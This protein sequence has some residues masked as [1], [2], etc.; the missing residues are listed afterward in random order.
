MLTINV[1][2]GN[3]IDSIWIFAGRNSTGSSASQFGHGG[4]S[5]D[6]T[7]WSEISA[8][9][10]K[11][12]DKGSKIKVKP[13]GN[14]QYYVFGR[15]NI[16]ETDPSPNA[17]TRIYKLIVAYS[18]VGAASEWQV[19]GLDDV[20]WAGFN[21]TGTETVSV[22]RLLEAKHEYKFKLYN[23]STS[24]WWGNGTTYQMTQGQTIE[25]ADAGANCK[26]RT[27][28]AGT[29]TFSFNTSTKVL[30]VIY[31]DDYKGYWTKNGASWSKVYA[32]CYMDG[33]DSWR[34]AEWPGVEITSQTE[35]IC[36]T[37][38][39]INTSGYTTVIFN[40]GSSG[41]GNQTGNIAISGGEG[42]HAVGAAATGWTAYPTYTV[43]YD[44]NENTGGSVPTDS[45]SP[46][47]CGS[48]VTVLGNT[49]S[50]VR[51]GYNFTGWN[52]EANGSGTGYTA[53]KTF[54]ISANTTLY[55]QW[56]LIPTYDITY[57][58]NEGTGTT[59]SQTG[60]L[61]GAVVA[62]RANGFT[63]S[64]YKFKWW[65]T[66]ADGSGEDFYPGEKVTIASS[67]VT[68]YAQWEQV[69]SG[70][71][72][73]VGDDAS[74]PTDIAGN[75]VTM[76]LA[77][78]ADYNTDFS[79]ASTVVSKYN[80][81]VDKRAKV[82]GIGADDKYVEISFTDG[83]P[84]NS[85]KLGVAGKDGA[86]DMIVIYSTTADFSSGV[87]EKV[88]AA[89][90]A[91]T[92]S[93]KQVKDFS[94]SVANKYFYARVY[95]NVTTAIYGLTGGS[96][97][98]IRVYSIK[99]QK[100]VSCVAPATVNV[101]ATVNSV[102]GFQ[103]YPDDD[104]VLT[105]TPTG[106]P[107]G[108]PVTYQ[109]KKNGSNVGTNS[110]TLTIN[111]AAASDAG[112]YTCTISYGA[113]STTSAEFSLKCM[114]FLLKN[115]SGEDIGTP[116]ALIKEDATHATL[117][118]NLTGGTTYKFRV[119][120][121]CNNWYGNSD[122]TGITSS[123]CTNWTMPH[124][125]D[126]KVTTNSKTGTYTFNFDFTGGV[127]GSEMKVSIVYPGGNQAAG[128]IIYWDNSVL[129]W[130]AGKQWYR[131]GK[132]GHNNKTQMELVPGTANLYTITTT[133]YNGFEYWHIA[134]N[135]GEGT[136][137]IFWTKGEAA[138]AITHAMAFEEAP[139]TADAV[140]VTPSSS[141]ARGTSADNDNCDFYEYGQQEGMKTQN[142]SI[143]APSNGTI[144]VAYTDVEGASQSFTSGSADLAHTVIITPTATPNTGYTLSGLTVNEAAHTSGNTY[145]VTANTTIAATFT[146]KTYNITLDRN[147]ASSGSESVTMTYNS[148]SYTAITAPV[149]AGYT[150]DGWYDSET[151]NN[152][153]GNLVMN[154]SGVLQANVTGFTGAG[155]I[156]IKDATCTLYA[157]WTVKTTTITIDANTSNH[158]STAPSP[159]TATYSRA[160]PSF[161][162]AAG[163]GGWNLT[164]YFTAA[165][166]GTKV[167]N[168][169][170]TLVA[171][172]D[173]ADGDG[174]WKY[175][176]AT[177]T[178]YAQYE[179]D[180]E[181]CYQFEVATSGSAPSVGDAVLGTGDAGMTV[182]AKGDGSAM[183]YNSYGIKFDKSGDKLRV[184]LAD[185]IQIG[186]VIEIKQY[187]TGEG[188]NRGLDIKTTS[189]E[190]VTG[191]AMAWNPA[192]SAEEKI[193][194]LT[195][196][197]GNELIDAN[198]FLLVRKTNTYLKSVTVSNCGDAACS[199]P[200]IDAGST[201]LSF[202]GGTWAQ[203]SGHS[204]TITATGADSYEWYRNTAANDAGATKLSET[205]NTLD[206]T[207]VT[208]GIYFFKAVAKSGACSSST[209][210][211]WCGA[212]TI[213]ASGYTVTYNGNGATSGSVPVDASSP[214]ASGSNVTV[215]GNTG[216]LALA[217]YTFDGWATANDGTGTNYTADGT[218]SGIAADVELFAKWKQSITL[219]ANTSN[220]GTG[221]N[222]EATV[223]Y[224]AT[225]LSSISHATPAS[226]YKLLGYYTTA[227]GDGVKV[228]N[229]DGTFAGSN[230]T[231][232]IT[233]G[234]WS[235][236]GAAP[237][238]Y[239]R[240]ESSGALIWNLG[241]NTEATSLTTSSKHSDFTQIAGSNMAVAAV[242]GLT[243]T[244]N[245]KANLTGIIEAPTSYDGA[246]YVSVTFQVA[247][248]YKFTPSSVNVKV[249][250]K[251]N[252]KT[253]KIELSDASSH[254]QNYTSGSQSAG[255]IQ[256]VT[257]TGNGTFYTG[258][259]TLKIYCYGASGGY[260]LGTPITIEG[261]VE[262]TCVMPSFDGLNYEETSYNLD[263]NASAITVTNPANV[264][265][266][267][268]K[269]NTTNDRSGTTP[270]S[271]TN[272]KASYTPPTSEAGTMYYWCE[273]ISDCGTV[274]TPA[275]GI[276]V[277]VSKS[278]ATISWTGTSASANYGGG[279]YTVKATVNETGWDGNAADLTLSAP[280]GIHI[281][282]IES[283][284]ADGKKYVQASFDVTTAFDRGTY[285][286]TIPFVVSA[287][288][289][290]TYNA[291]SDEHAV[292]YEACTGAGEGESYKIRMRKVVTKDGNYYHCANT[293]GWI[294]ANISSSYS[295]TKASTTMAKEFDTVA[296][297]N[298]QYVWVRTYHANINKVRIYAD[299][300]AGNMTV[301]N[302]YK[303]TNYFSAD[304]KYA[305][306]YK[307]IYNG[308]E[309]YDDLGET[310]QGYVDIE[311]G[312][313]L[314]ANDVLLVA[315]NTK[316]VRPLGAVITEGSAGSLNTHLQWSG[317]LEDGATVNK[318]TTDAYFTYSASM[319]T[320]NTN[321]LG[322][323]TY[324]SS[325]PSVATVDATGKVAMVAAGTTT[326]KATLA[327]SGCYKKAEISYTLNVTEDACAIAAGT[328]TLTSGSESKCSGE[329][330]TLT[331]TDFESDATLQWKDGDT[332]I[333]NDG[334]Y[335]IV[336]DGTTS[337]LTTKQPGT[338]SVIVKKNCFV[339][340][341]RITITYK[342]TSV[343]VT[344]LVKEWY[345]KNGRL[346]PDI[347]LW[348]LGDDCSF[349]SVA[350]SDGWD[351]NTGLTAESS[352]YEQDGVVYLKGTEP[353]ANAETVQ[354]YTLTLTVN[355]GCG[356]QTLNAEGMKITIHHQQNTDKHV[357]AFVVNGT[358]KGGFTDGITAAQTTSVGLYNSIA[359]QFDV[360]ET[361]IYATDDEKKLKEYYSQYDILCL[362]D[363]PNTKT[364]GANSKSY[365]DA[366]GALI[367]IRPVLTM[368]AWV[369]GLSNWNKKGISGNPKNPTTRQYTME[370]QCKDHEIFAGTTLTE[371]GEGDEK[372]Y[373]VTMVDKNQE[374]YKTLD[375]NYGDGEHKSNEGYQYGKKPALQGFTYT[376]EMSDNDL[377]PLG[378]IDDGT[379]NDLQVGLERQREMSARMM[380]LGINSYAMERLTDDG[381]RIVIN[382]LK[383]LMKKNAEDIADC[384]TSFVGG[385]DGDEYNWMN[386]DNWTGNTV[387]DKT[388]KVRIL[389]PCVVPEGER[390][391][392][393][394][395][396]IAPN[397]GGTYNGG[398]TP[399]TGS[400]TIAAGGA[401][402]VEG[403]IQAVT[404]PAYNRPRATTP[405]DLTI[406]TDAD[407]QG[408]LIFDNSEGETQ[409]TVQMYSPSYWEIMEG[410][411]KKKSYW[412]YVAIPIQDAYVG[413]FF[414]GAVTYLYDETAGWIRKRIGTH[415]HAFEG[416]GL[417]LPEGHTE[418]FYGPLAPTEDRTVT[419]T[420]TTS[421][422]NGENLIGNSWTAPIQIAN[423]E[424]SDFGSATQNVMIYSTGRDG[425]QDGKIENAE[426]VTA[427]VENDGNV[428][429]G[430]WISIP[431]N[432]PSLD[433]YDGLKVIPA[434]QAFQVTTGT[435]TSLT[436]NYDKLVRDVNIVSDNLTE[437][438]HA[439]A[440]R[441]SGAKK[442]L[443]ST[444]RVRVSGVKTRT[445]VWLLEDDRFSEAFDNGWEA[446]YAECDDR[447]A[448]LY[449]Q[450]ETGNMS[451]LAKS[452][453]EGTVLGFAP[454]KD[455]N[456][457]LF[458][459]HYVGD[460][461]YYL[462]D[463]KLTTATLISAENSYLFTYEE[464]DTNR[465]Y[466]SRQ[467]LG[468]PAVATGV[469][470]PREE[471]KPRKFIYN[472]K[473]YILF[474][475][476]V[477]D[478][479]GKVVK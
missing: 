289:T 1:G 43:T 157:K 2:T 417:S 239:A 377:L 385:A 225:A 309:G 142:V 372:M 63:R 411:N 319:I 216:S 75:G 30:T 99:A 41:E 233:A 479:T 136:K 61:S 280:A 31:P 443:I 384:S 165:I 232:Y 274:K 325:N 371:V 218:I 171:G 168:A 244:G 276:T 422:G 327:A 367:D 167:I 465:F 166:G 10:A 418:T 308:D 58:A 370:L 416:I 400:L 328:L 423:F 204:I 294:S 376:E 4:F 460:D 424:A 241:V 279:G 375:A 130:E 436:L 182:E 212:M 189:D 314:E 205:S 446:K 89:T 81:S 273:L 37:H 260:R 193:M 349:V 90:Y 221:D 112:R 275:I 361:N 397:D 104:V 39:Y 85:L 354:N 190:S 352:F 213:T 95:R 144:S 306:D 33:D 26:L 380:V 185:K 153:S 301:A 107:A 74:S 333:T 162:P 405:A 215:L 254:S 477:F 293:D 340:S 305:V 101:T 257:M 60:N 106:A 402:V 467:P 173:Y 54:T 336:T 365:V 369:S 335:T 68:L 206:I 178:V 77:R 161:T 126:C 55:A 386:A 295:T 246:K 73:W 78:T 7:S 414:Y 444:M 57:N 362:T 432:V 176:T 194:R 281:Y 119:T 200:V 209:E 97:H 455:G 344:P 312:N 473:M 350:A 219:D 118:L 357:L 134:N 475:G 347:A 202:A 51:T 102:A 230:V 393:A 235:R 245:A 459:F 44:G 121:G 94:P 79:A 478:A 223:M 439:P 408:A 141:H 425:T 62:T 476:R 474:N 124:D 115:S 237:T 277:S 326:I 224:N 21:M 428:N 125:A 35:D 341:N 346:T 255:S 228:L 180:A 110:A 114:Q 19:K 462:N 453:I 300:R 267:A 211:G 373:R 179:E 174:K 256:T 407:A 59:A 198:A 86:Y 145:T 187:S 282:N 20:N 123:N 396:L 442:S 409:A 288:A 146:A 368:E 70:W 71:A 390:A 249:Q 457:Y 91:A 207:D 201:K 203:N 29:Y 72:Y 197:A 113:C 87:G 172:T 285:S 109:W 296:S 131:I 265:T 127:R 13:S 438:Q 155:G 133:A 40:N 403:K 5:T 48:T 440:R 332:D 452:D 419:L 152:G 9:S 250:P 330:V 217:N 34:N 270:A 38:Y 52:T 339:R 356:N 214:Y 50:L 343:H 299:F 253:V 82:F 42:K 22:S 251:D 45:N 318:K 129:N 84:I 320:E 177:L 98:T 11:G 66:K 150:F 321:S 139:V 122:A 175:E 445:D 147:G 342:S 287:D 132:N 353:K 323:L 169:D 116:H 469:D 297:S 345:I 472:D 398:S 15:G 238:L 449:A 283:G 3:K 170:G 231:D 222:T 191:G 148:S 311:L 366:I 259:V 195:I 290:A 292:N 192:E 471:A 6:S 80:S 111:G 108:S 69:E 247:A 103:F 454:S 199:N 261:E 18:A 76:R 435:E 240:Y 468:A 307:V 25:Q 466:I 229:S 315:F 92:Q 24:K 429:A 322:A 248:G 271:G 65:N 258:T 337:T 430:Q 334:N 23:T 437:K 64:G 379:G 272:N 458:T 151:D 310:A 100:G 154:A 164:G 431:I 17:E 434:M 441:S 243:Y 181:A 226:G 67:N 138:H 32:Y 236:T 196:A 286:T 317:S 210:W 363:Y 415:L 355:D 264:T 420:K 426:Y 303:S 53:G 399:T 298:T 383:Y 105:A 463:L 186:T 47:A 304:S 359:A 28:K 404:A 263:D 183:A 159:I 421:G 149:K 88:V 338:Y 291:I 324:S 392:V 447:S 135:D 36:G 46:Y 266:Y 302:V 268:W 120:D 391:H 8:L 331:L 456:Q 313:V 56:E 461:E 382:A 374:E 316:K 401:L 410:T 284:T 406:L 49:G 388:Q 16:G 227:S 451:F 329:Y 412:S 143:T 234:K 269:Q 470:N 83:S 208:P 389:A 14:Y 184:T 364:T 351:A 252:A 381:E 433:G 387:P 450:S 278:D 160:L 137:N 93:T 188:K 395:V 427:T 117:D 348:E 262:A 96:A 27:S 242:T 413:E 464:G 156:W 394:G 128:K 360:Q 378:L 140:T 158:G 448:Q 163:I 12:Y 358:E 220:H